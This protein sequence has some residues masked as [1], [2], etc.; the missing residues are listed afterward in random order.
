MLPKNTGA[1]SAGN[2]LKHLK[3]SVV[4]ELQK[5]GRKPRKRLENLFSSQPGP[6][7]SSSYL[8]VKENV[9]L[10]RRTWFEGAVWRIL[11]CEVGSERGKA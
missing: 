2:L 3:I 5:E 11:G 8:M 6:L 1:T 7:Q 10:L 9:N 4:L